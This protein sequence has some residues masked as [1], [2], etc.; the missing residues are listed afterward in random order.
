MSGDPQ[1]ARAGIVERSGH[2]LL[3]ALL[4]GEQLAAVVPITLAIVERDPL[5]SAGYFPGDLV[6]GLMEVSGHFWGRHQRMYERYVHA[7]RAC[8][9]ERRLLPRHA[10]MEFWSPLDDARLCAT[11]CPEGGEPPAERSAS[12]SKPSS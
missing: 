12:P 5:A 9:A 3:R 10:R 7:L 2:E 4:A 6:R 11:T 8:A 1:R